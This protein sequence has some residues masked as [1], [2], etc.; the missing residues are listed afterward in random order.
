MFDVPDMSEAARRGFAWVARE[1]QLPSHGHLQALQA[2]FVDH[3]NDG[4]RGLVR[5]LKRAWPEGARWPDG[6]SWLQARAQIPESERALFDDYCGDGLMGLLAHR[7][8]NVTQR[9]YRDAQVRAAVD[10][11][12][13]THD[14]IYTHVCINRDHWHDGERNAC[15]VKKESLVSIPAGLLF[16]REPVHKH[17]ACDCT[18]DPHP[19]PGMP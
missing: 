10:P 17:P 13:P 19:A 1:L 14:A 5:A 8:V 2:A 15:G 18:A 9:V 4:A 3:Q 11:R 12:S 6:E 7:L 16:L